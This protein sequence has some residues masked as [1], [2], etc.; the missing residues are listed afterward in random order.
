MFTSLGAGAGLGWRFGLV[1]PLCGRA[2][3]FVAGILIL[4][5]GLARLWFC[6]NQGGRQEM[7]STST[8]IH[9]TSTSNIRFTIIR[10]ATPISPTHY[11][12]LFILPP[13]G[14]HYHMQ[15]DFHLDGWFRLIPGSD[16]WGERAD[17]GKAPHNMA[18]LPLEYIGYLLYF[19]PATSLSGTLLHGTRFR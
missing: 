14:H 6:G 5:P 8:I 4:I 15:R 7:I 13:P 12:P 16:G 3:A 1:W 18:G 9:P 11:P 2:R 10:H 19:Q 17:G